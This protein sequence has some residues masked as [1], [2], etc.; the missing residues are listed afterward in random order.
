MNML[1]R[2]GSCCRPPPGGE[3][4]IV[5]YN[6]LAGCLALLCGRTNEANGNT[7]AAVLMNERGNRYCADE[8]TKQA[9]LITYPGTVLTKERNK[10]CYCA[11]ERTKLA[12]LLC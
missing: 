2:Q 6:M 8:R 3:F 9:L 11:D 10:H 7:A 5:R 1:R 12:L 4:G